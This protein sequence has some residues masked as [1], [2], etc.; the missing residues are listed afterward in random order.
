MFNFNNE[1][2]CAYCGVAEEIMTVDHIHPTSKGG[3]NHK[4]NRRISCKS[5]NSMK[6]N[7][8]TDEFRELLGLK[9]M[10]LH[11]IIGLPTYKRLKDFGVDM[12]EIP[13]IKFH[14]EY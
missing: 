2:K 10:G 3:S 5:C 8:S 11:E 9:A 12:P 14:F 4:S 6:H 13:H 1:L 7:K